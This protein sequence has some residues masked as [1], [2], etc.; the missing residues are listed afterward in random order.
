M[1]RKPSK[2]ITYVNCD[3]IWQESKEAQKIER[4]EIEEVV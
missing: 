2:A 1:S 4:Q 3:R